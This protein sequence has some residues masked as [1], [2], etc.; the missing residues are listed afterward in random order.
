MR[1][2]PPAAPSGG[3]PA[4]AQVPAGLEDGYWVL[5]TVLAD[6]TPDMTVARE[7]IF[8][9]VAVLLPYDEEDDAVAIANDSEY[10]LSG[11][12]WSADV[13]RAVAVGRRIETGRVVINGGEFDVAAPTG[14][15][16]QSGN[17]RELGVPGL[18]EYL[19]V[20]VFQR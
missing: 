12:V 17:G 9:P 2:S 3:T 11:A 18:L 14:G 16:K 8:G 6:V 19:E 13:A 5:P 1:E 4:P 20:K 7:E 10:G 15:A